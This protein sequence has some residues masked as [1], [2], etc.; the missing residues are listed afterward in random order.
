[1]EKTKCKPGPVFLDD[2]KLLHK[3]FSAIIVHNLK[4][5]KT[6]NTQENCIPPPAPL[7]PD[8]HKK[9]NKNI[10]VHPLSHLQANFGL[11]DRTEPL[12]YEIFLEHRP[13]KASYFIP[14]HTSQHCKHQKAEQLQI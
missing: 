10:M 5:R 11:R 1:M 7:P 3:L 14:Q 13:D 8:P 9:Q 2:R 6:I 12:N 4:G